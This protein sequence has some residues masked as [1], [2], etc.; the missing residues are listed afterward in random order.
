MD[1]AARAKKALEGLIYSPKPG[2]DVAGDVANDGASAAGA[3]AD[4]TLFSMLL[5]FQVRC[6]AAPI[7]DL[8]DH[9]MQRHC[10]LLVTPSGISMKMLL[11]YTLAQWQCPPPCVIITMRMQDSTD[12]GAPKA[13]PWERSDLVR[14]LRSF[15]PATWFC[16]PAPAGPTECARRGWVNAGQDLLSC[17][18]HLNSW[19]R[20]AAAHTNGMSGSA[21][22]LHS[23]LHLHRTLRPLL[24]CTTMCSVMHVASCVIAVLQGEA[25]LFAA[26]RPVT[27]GDQ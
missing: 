26:G 3:P 17:E 9:P 12:E 24:L 25:C 6:K 10:H 19:L 8:S 21:T 4:A 2:S 15:R 20:S 14:R 13:R 22:V 5:D 16:K 27:R 18:V 11:Q 1:H 7:N 23:S